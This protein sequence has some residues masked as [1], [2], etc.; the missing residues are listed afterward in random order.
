MAALVDRLFLLG[1]SFVFLAA[2]DHDITAVSAFL[3]AVTISALNG[4]LS[5]KSILVVSVGF[6]ALLGLF[7][8]NFLFFLPLVFYDFFLHIHKSKQ[9]SLLALPAALLVLSAVKLPVSYALMIGL[10]LLSAYILAERMWSLRTGQEQMRELRDGSGEMTM[11]LQQKNQELLEHQASR[12]HMA[13]LNE[14][15]RIA[16]EIHDHVGHLLSRSI[17]QIG[18]LLV[19]EEKEQTSQHLAAVHTTLSEAMD[20]IRTSVHDLYEESLDFASQVEALVK[21]FR[22]CPLRL[23]YKLETVPS[24]EI[25]HCLLAI[26]KEGLNNV[27]RHSNASQVTLILLEHPALYQLVLQDNGTKQAKPDQT[28]LGLISMA[29]RVEALGGRL[30]IER[31]GGFRLF[32]SIPKGGALLEGVG[33]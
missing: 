22:F 14:R 25:Q 1:G 11:L 19:G 17:L 12:L 28:G 27:V 9:R 18:A 21:E 16:R 31:E 24:R 3:A 15:G 33:N 4:L 20:R 7:W 30:L 23:D 8:P 29:D 6:F 32:I 10:V 5:S 13:K 2:Y 26:I